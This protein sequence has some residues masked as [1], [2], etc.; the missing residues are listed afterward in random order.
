MAGLLMATCAYK[1]VIAG[2][3]S[4]I[5]TTIYLLKMVVGLH[6]IINF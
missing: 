6:F 2:K 5:K 4:N 3:T 1:Q